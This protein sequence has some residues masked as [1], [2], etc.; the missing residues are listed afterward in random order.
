MATGGWDGGI[1]RGV[2]DGH[3]EGW[4]GTSGIGIRGQETLKGEDHHRSINRRAQRMDGRD[5]ITREIEEE[6]MWGRCWVVIWPELNGVVRARRKN[7][8]DRLVT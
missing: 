2:G 6:T 1:P 8:R 5:P 3:A 7:A 4:V